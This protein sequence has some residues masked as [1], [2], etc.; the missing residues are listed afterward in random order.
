[1]KDLN[2]NTRSG[3][4]RLYYID[5]L[6]VLAFGLL[7]IFHAARFFDI[8][9]W[10]VKNAAHSEIVNV[11]VGFTHGWR[12]HLIFFISGVGTFF[13]LK[14]RN[15]RFVKDRFKRLIV[16]FIF[17]IIL[18]IPPQKFYEAI[19]NGWF[20]GNALDFAINYPSWLLIKHP[21]ISLSWTGHVGLHIWYLAFL[22]V[23][24]I[25]ALPL[26]KAFTRNNII[27]KFFKAVSGT[28][29]GI[30]LFIVPIILFEIVLRPLFPGYLDWADFFVYA[31]YFITGYIFMTQRSFVESTHKYTYYFLNIGILTTAL[32]AY[33][34]SNYP[35]LLESSS[36]IV[37][38]ASS[39]ISSL[40]AF[41]W[42]MF[43]FGLSQ[44]K[45][46]FN[47]RLLNSLN[48]GILPFYIL[49][50]TVIILI[51]YYII[52][53]DLNILSKFSII[54]SLSLA[55]TIGLYQ[56]IRRFAVLR[57]LFGMKVKI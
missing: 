56:I 6:R 50:Q 11:F 48:V 5:W 41:S 46:N 15:G 47:H 19:S 31:M 30:F 45:L 29:L 2:S 35:E 16:P 8:Y 55:V 9:P 24:T 18:L 37:F 20:D 23:M 28:R 42:V 7:F 38:I 26:L 49:H 36:P 10:H 14:S 34:M 27:T 39:F 40:N 1:M 52:T 54:L 43:L 33:L 3:T 21:G 57:L 32:S 25:A 53:L 17:G 12:M 22:F 51:G 4:E 44:R 13:A